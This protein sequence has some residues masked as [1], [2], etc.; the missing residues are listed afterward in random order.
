MKYYM[1]KWVSMDEIYNYYPCFQIFTDYIEAR[2]FATDK[3]E[4]SFNQ[5]ERPDE[6]F[7]GKIVSEVYLEEFKIQDI[8]VPE[9]TEIN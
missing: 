8:V 4:E 1:V 5:I 3:E 7:E 9:G 6:L 2:N